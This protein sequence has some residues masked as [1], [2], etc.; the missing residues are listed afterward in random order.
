MNG[1][2]K[3]EPKIGG[4]EALVM[5]GVSALFDIADFFATFLDA[6]LGAG[7]LVKFFINVAASVLLWLWAIMRDVGP[8][9]VLAGSL[10]EFIPLVNT[11]PL[12][13]V[14]TASTIWLDWHPKEAEIAESLLPKLKN[15]KRAMGKRALAEKAAKT[16]QAI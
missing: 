15:P 14:T 5:V 1:E 13:T 4:V 10:L 7:E 12:R 6:L 8:T 11:L 9:R 2:N 3:P 16:T